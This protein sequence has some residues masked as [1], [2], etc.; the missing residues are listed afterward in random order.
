MQYIN[1]QAL[2]SKIYKEHLPINKTKNGP[3]NRKMG[4]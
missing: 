4:K 1:N 3:S 2:M